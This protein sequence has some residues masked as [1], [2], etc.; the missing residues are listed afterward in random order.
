MGGEVTVKPLTNVREY[1][2][3][4]ETSRNEALGR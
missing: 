2:Y 4:S 3:W 1:H